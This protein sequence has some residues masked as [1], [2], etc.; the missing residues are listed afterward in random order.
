MKKLLL[1][2]GILT[3]S[4]SPVLAGKNHHGAMVVHTDDAYG[5]TAGVCGNFDAWVP[6][7]C[8]Y[9]GTRTDNDEA[10]PSLIWLIAAFP[11]NSNPVVTGVYFGLDH[12]LP[13]YH[14]NRYGLCGPSGSIEIPDYGW[15]DAP[16]TAGNSV[17][18]GSPIVGDK[19]FAFYYVDVWGFE[20]AYYGTGINPVGGNARFVDD[21]NPPEEDECV[22]FGQ[23][24]WYEEGYNDDVHC[25]PGWGACCFQDG[26]CTVSGADD[27]MVYGGGYFW[28]PDG[29]CE[30]NPCLTAGACCRPSGSCYMRIE[31][32]CLWGDG[33]FMGEGVPCDPNPCVASTV[34]EVWTE[35]VTWGRIKS[36]YLE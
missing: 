11:Y 18:F 25:F 12:N 24:R 5:W 21:S 4:A 29:V 33:E 22:Y 10:T 20:G 30:P 13:E 6:D 16:S 23:V 36:T 35:T 15:P 3:L 7:I 19:L 34:P 27:C 26:T 31:D 1:L 9:F 2:L 28:I 17:A 8:T 32:H 14:H